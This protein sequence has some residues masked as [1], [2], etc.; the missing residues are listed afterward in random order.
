MHENGHQ[1]WGDNV[2]VKR[3]RDICLSECFASYS[4]WLWDEHNGDDLD[5]RYHALIDRD[6]SFFEAPLYDM[7]PGHEFDRAGV[8]YKGTFFLHALRNK[9]GDDV[10][11]S[12]MRA[13]QR[14]EAGGNISMLGLRDQL[15][16]RTGVDLAG[17]WDE[18]VITT[19]TPS[20]AHLYPGDL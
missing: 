10:F 19:G 17:F 4:V 5:A 13:I 2:S 15:Q 18:W 3:W 20:D 14:D 9:L 1:W 12:A 11:F 16:R 6:G 7:G 8:Y